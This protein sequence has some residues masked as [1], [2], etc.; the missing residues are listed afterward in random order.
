MNRPFVLCH[1]LASLDGKVTGEFLNDPRAE[2]A[3]KRYYKMHRDYK[4]NA[5]AC[6]R[7]TMEESFTKGYYPDLSEFSDEPKEFKDRFD[8][9]FYTFYAVCFDR[10]GKLG[11]KSNTIE[12][13]E[14]G[15]NKAHVIEVLT[16]QVD[17]RYLRYLDSLKIPYIFAGKDDIDINL[18]LKKLYHYFNISKLLLEGG[19][20][21]NSAF[22]KA[23]AIDEVNVVV[24][25]LIAN[26]DDKPLFYDCNI[27]PV[28]Y[29]NSRRFKND[30][31]TYNY[32]I[33]HKQFLKLNDTL[34]NQVKNYVKVKEAI[35]N[36]TNITE[37]Y[38]D[39]DIR[40]LFNYS[41]VILEE[42]KYKLKQ[43]GK[44]ECFDLVDA[45]ILQPLL[46]NVLA[47]VLQQ[48]PI[49]IKLV[50]DRRYHLFI[51]KETK[52]K[53]LVS[54]ID[55]SKNPSTYRAEEYDVVEYSDLLK[56]LLEDVDF[57]SD[58][59]IMKLLKENG[60]S[61]EDFFVNQILIVP[62]IFYNKQNRL[63]RSLYYKLIVRSNR[64]NAFLN[65]ECP[66]LIR[67]N[68]QR[69]LHKAIFDLCEQLY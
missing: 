63:S 50:L 61:K 35:A 15:Y 30:V 7:V 54:H 24:A 52:V 13:E 44:Y 11:W 39:K 26:K 2:H 3:I 64:L 5:F 9:P 66:H 65:R 1:M 59:E 46:V 17:V 47:E 40:F 57:D 22:L 32:F 28:T 16:E 49:F 42:E 58:R 23:D 10:Y 60:I 55:Y 62:E 45:N 33:S 56:L 43:D 27:T 53:S 51:N 8:C 19:S 31:L 6:G 25:P 48:E 21:I 14:E 34:E 18:A 69:L 41:K 20:I 12:D 4:Y 29:G 68:E 37:K 67:L 36:A 38:N